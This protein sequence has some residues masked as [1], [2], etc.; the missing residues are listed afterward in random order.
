MVDIEVSVVISEVVVENVSLVEGVTVSVVI[1]EVVYEEVSL[2]EAVEVDI[3]IEEIE[4]EVV[5]EGVDVT[6]LIVEV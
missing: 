4:I 2:T 1:S 5:V 6:S 3:E